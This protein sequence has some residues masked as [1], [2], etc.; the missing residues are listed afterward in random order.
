ML[1]KN[2]PEFF[3]DTAF[4]GALRFFDI[5][6]KSWKKTW[7]QL[8][9][10]L[11]PSIN[12]FASDAFGTV[13]GISNNEVVIFWTETGELEPLGMNEND[14]YDLIVEDPDNTINLGL[15][16]QATELFGVLSKD[17]HFAFKIETALGGD[18][19]LNNIT[20]MNGVDHY[21][22]LGKLANQ[23]NSLPEGERIDS[24]LLSNDCSGQAK[25]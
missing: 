23:I 6:D 2:L 8:Y 19:S 5:N 16:C 21:K 25:K 4:K 12:I 3:G 10:S 17:D 13:Y 9:G 22:S 11:I 20:V 14:F 24:I 15:Y 18:L 7:G 1:R